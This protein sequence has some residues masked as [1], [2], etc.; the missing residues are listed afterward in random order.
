MARQKKDQDDF[1]L[2]RELWGASLELEALDRQRAAALARR[3]V[4]VERLRERGYTWERVA[5]LARVS[6]TSL[7]KRRRDVAG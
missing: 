4:V 3:D 7:Q 1:E 2:E 5:G 6:T